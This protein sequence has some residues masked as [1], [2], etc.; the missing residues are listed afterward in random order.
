MLRART[1]STNPVVKAVRHKFGIPKLILA[2]GFLMWLPRC[3]SQS[4]GRKPLS[5]HPPPPTTPFKDHHMQM[6][7]T[8]NQS[9][10]ALLLSI[11]L[12][13]LGQAASLSVWIALIAPP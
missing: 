5:Y 8:A 4:L 9:P 11:L 6:I 12:P 7:A 1:T 2:Q 13:L 10:K 3:P